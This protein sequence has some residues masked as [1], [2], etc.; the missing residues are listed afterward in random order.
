MKLKINSDCFNN[1]ISVSC[2]ELRAYFIIEKNYILVFLSEKKYNF[3]VHKIEI[4]N[5]S[6]DILKNKF[7][8]LLKMSDRNLISSIDKNEERKDLSMMLSDEIFINNLFTCINRL[9][10]L[11][12]FW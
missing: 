6:K 12:I 1:K 4:D 2:K 11:S 7:I 10:H 5:L 9:K 3:Y 8:F